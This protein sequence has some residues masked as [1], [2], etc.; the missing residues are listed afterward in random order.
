MYKN[1]EQNG[2]LQYL[3]LTF[4]IAW[5]TEAA[6]I[7]GERLEI[8]K[9]AAGTALIFLLIGFGAGF[10]PAY[11]VCILLKKQ[12]KV[13][14]FKDIFR[15]ILH[16]P[17]IKQAIWITAIFLASQL[18]VNAASEEY[19]GNP[20]YL[21]ILLLPVMVI[22]GGVE[23]L[24]WRGFLQPQLEKRFPF[25]LSALITGVIWGCWHMPLW[26]V[27]T[28]NQSVMNFPSFL[29]YCITFG[30]VLGLL[31]RLTKSIFACVL[32]HA[33]GNLLQ[34]MFTRS[35]LTHPVSIKMAVLWGSE[36][37]MAIIV[38]MLITRLKKERT[39][40]NTYK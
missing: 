8:L 22:G 20:W 23:E 28:S 27:Q 1:K 2:I 32:L 26:F 37:L 18:L 3:M 31:Y 11:A 33:W 36:I 14:G 4:L 19:T 38:S 29:L 39:I 10:A 24:G 7:A 40:I 16:T 13:K 30:F 15:L 9:G 6:I 34:G 12:G 21:F 5:G 35:A 25:A 17:N